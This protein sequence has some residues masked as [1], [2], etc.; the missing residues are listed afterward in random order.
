MLGKFFTEWE[1]GPWH[2]LP[3]G[4]VDALYLEVSKDRLDWALDHL[5]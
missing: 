3:R 2:R 1:V 5:I 4:A